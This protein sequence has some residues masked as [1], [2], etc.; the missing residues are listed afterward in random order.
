MACETG[1]ARECLRLLQASS[2]RPASPGDRL[3]YSLVTGL[4]PASGS[5][6]SALTVPVWPISHSLLYNRLCPVFVSE[7]ALLRE[8]VS[9]LLWEVTCS[10]LQYRTYPRGE[11]SAF[12]YMTDANYIQNHSD[13]TVISSEFRLRQL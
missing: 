4:E 7:V 3:L 11:R 6:M 9:P 2:A 1:E 5:A 12:L 10:D 13:Y 8:S